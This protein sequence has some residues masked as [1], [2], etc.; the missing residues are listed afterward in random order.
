MNFP[1]KI[2]L[3]EDDPAIVLT[4]RRV[5]ADE[6]Y[7]VSVENNGE[8]GLERAKQVPFD[9]VL[10][11]LKLPGRNGLELVRELHGIR[12]RLPILM[13]TAHGTTETAIEAT[14]AGAYDYLLKPF[15]MPELIKLVAQAVNASRLMTEPVELGVQTARTAIVGNSRAMQAIYKE[16]GRIAAKPVSVLIRGE[17]GTGKE[18]IARAI[19]QHSDRVNAPFV[20][21]NCAAI[22]ETLLESELFGHERGAFTGAESRR[23]GRFEQ[24]D[25]GT[26]FLD[27]IGDMTP[28]TQVKLMRVLQEKCL[29]RLGGK[30]TIPVDVRV[31]AA[32]HR[33]LEAAIRQKQFRED[34]YYR[35]SVVVLSL[36]P[37]RE[38]RDDI[39]DLV[40]F[41][42]RKYS[43]E[44]NGQTAAIHPSAI[45]FLQA[46]PW[47]G[48]V[49]ELENVTRKML[50]LAQ[51][52]TI[53]IEHVRAALA[54]ATVPAASSD[55]TLQGCADE[56]LAAA[57]QGESTD[58]YA[59]MHEMTDRILL[60]RAIERAQGN[61]AKAARWLGISRLTL[62]EKLI[63]FGLHPGQDS[64]NGDQSVT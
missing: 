13:M 61:Q 7:D 17:T 49:R 62:R 51:N 44:F 12:P 39:P 8:H 55:K 37:L 57:Q 14:Q 52:Y 2:L 22:P 1:P 33:D 20:A 15:E 46:Q 60:R 31:I 3:V 47:P 41:F 4:L 35:I 32:T 54:R 27:E 24:A 23:I 26:I 53:S 5:L 56:L 29:Q 30:E 10:T 38:R 11:D 58:V 43:S 48:N 64:S 40:R 25:R 45:E 34:L 18:L 59:Q 19:Y 6:G 16:I 9:L 63:Q 50:L 21:I 28:G 42:L 36:P